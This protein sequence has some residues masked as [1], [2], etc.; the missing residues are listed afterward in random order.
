M[1]V[2]VLESKTAEEI[3]QIWTEYHKN[4]QSLSA[5]IPRETYDKITELAQQCPVFVY[6]VPRDDGYEFMLAQFLGDDCYFTPMISYKTH[7]ENAP[8]CLTLRHYTDIAAEKNIVLMVGEYDKDVVNVLEAQ[9][10]ANEVQLFYA[11]ES[12][13]RTEVVKKFNHSPESFDHMDLIRYFN[14]AEIPGS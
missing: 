14:S 11:Q 12:L 8:P 6:V 1:K 3:G 7:N 10:L 5:V 13:E 2:E 4:R 9:C